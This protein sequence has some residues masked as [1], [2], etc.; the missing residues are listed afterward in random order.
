MAA[1]RWL[2]L[3]SFYLVIWRMFS[4]YRPTWLVRLRERAITEKSDL[5]ADGVELFQRNE[6]PSRNYFLNYTV[7]TERKNFQPFFQNSSNY[8]L[9]RGLIIISDIERFHWTFWIATIGKMHAM[10]RD[11]KTQKGYITLIFSCKCMFFLH[12]IWHAC[13]LFFRT[14]I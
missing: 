1:E 8:I 12:I 5:R 3:F 9:N 4:F 14:C 6:Y 13:E 11:P 10:R 7:P 2:K